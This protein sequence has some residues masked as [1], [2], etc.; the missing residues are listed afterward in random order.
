MGI[1]RV[2]VLFLVVIIFFSSVSA[3]KK[4]APIPEVVERFIKNVERLSNISNE[5]VVLAIQLRGEMMGC[6]A[7]ND[8]YGINIDKASEHNSEFPYLGLSTVS[9]SRSYCVNLYMY[10]YEKH[11]LR[12]SHQILPTRYI[13][14]IGDNGKDERYFYSTPVKKTCEYKGRIKVLWQIFEVPI[15]ENKINSL[16]ITEKEPDGIMSG[17]K[18]NSKASGKN[19]E[20]ENNEFK[21]EE[22]TEQEC[23]RLAARYYTAEDYEGAYFTL[24]KLT[25]IYDSNAEG[26]YRL[27]LLIYYHHKKGCKGI[28]PNPRNVAI[29]FMK[30]AG[31]RA[32][33]KLKTTIYN[34]L[35]RWE[36]PNFM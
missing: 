30:K 26:W 15:G 7:G 13:N 1:K 8:V 32:K 19:Q 3:K 22:S 25:E 20:T 31:E 10:I 21:I 28:Y 11:I 36:H 6:F 18:N 2:L 14:I 17:K 23:L 9:N 5:D 12:F 16:K 29:S 33:G 4:E 35:F 27:A 24:K 34:Q